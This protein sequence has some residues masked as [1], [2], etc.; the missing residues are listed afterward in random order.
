[1]ELD[2]DSLR[3][4]QMLD[5]LNELASRDPEELSGILRRWMRNQD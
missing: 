3:R 2:D 4:Q 5:Q 1:M